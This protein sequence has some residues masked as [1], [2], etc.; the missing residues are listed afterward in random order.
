MKQKSQAFH[1]FLSI[2]MTWWFMMSKSSNFGSSSTQLKPMVKLEARRAS[3]RL[4]EGN[5]LW[6]LWVF[7]PDSQVPYGSMLIHVNCSLVPKKLHKL[8]AP[9]IGLKQDWAQ[10]NATAAS[11]DLSRRRSGLARWSFDLLLTD[12]AWMVWRPPKPREKHPEVGSN[13]PWFCSNQR[14]FQ[15]PEMQI[16]H[17]TGRNLIYC[18]HLK[19][20]HFWFTYYT[21][22]FSIAILDYEREGLPN[23]HLMVRSGKKNVSFFAICTWMRIQ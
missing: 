14:T 4:S 16:S 15:R 20:T 3:P 2:V 12:A 19:I 1:I 9:I 8:S 21:L 18:R 7:S 22:P 5:H 11:N 10:K 23:L 13:A 17:L 6:D